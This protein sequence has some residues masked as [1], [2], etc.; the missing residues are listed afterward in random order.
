MQGNPE[1]TRQFSF[2]WVILYGT[3]DKTKAFWIFTCF[4]LLF[5]VFSFVFREHNIKIDFNQ[6]NDNLNEKSIQ[7]ALDQGARPADR[8]GH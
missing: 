6:M 5:L 4:N 1:R 3:A 8:G 7:N 2:L